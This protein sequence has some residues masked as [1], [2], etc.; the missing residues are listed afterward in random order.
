MKNSFFLF[1]ALL[2]IVSSCRK[3]NDITTT[4][5]QNDLPTILVSGNLVGQI[6]DAD[7][8]VVPNAMV[9]VGEHTTHS[10]ELGL[11]RFNDIKMNSRGTYITAVQDGYFLGSDRI[12]PLNGSTNFSRIQLL[13][14]TL[15]GTVTNTDGGT[16]DVS[17]A[18]V[19]FEPNSIVDEQGNI[20]DGDVQ[21]FA[22]WLNPAAENLGDFMPGG[23]VGINTEREEVTM[24]SM[25]MLVV[26]LLDAAGNELNLADDKEAV[27][28][29]PIPTS[30]RNIAPSTIPL[31]HFDEEA[32]LW[33]EEGSAILE[34]DAYIGSVKHFTFWN[35]DFPYGT[36]TVDIQGCLKYEDGT[37]VPLYTFTVSIEGFGTIIWGQTD[38]QGQFHGPV[39]INE[40]LV[41]EFYDGCGNLQEYSVGPLT[42]DTVLDGCF[43]LETPDQL[44]FT[45]Q[46]VDCEG[47]GVN[48][49]VV[50]LK[51]FWPWDII[52]TDA[53]GNFSYSFNETCFDQNFNITAYD[54]ANNLATETISY[55]ITEDTNVG[56]ISVC[57][58]ELDE[59]LS[60]NADG[61]ELDFYDLHLGI[62]TLYY[63][64]DS[65]EFSYYSIINGWGF[66]LEGNQ[67]N[68]SLT[69]SSIEVGTYTGGEVA[70]SYYFNSAQQG[71]PSFGL[72]CWIP[73]NTVTINITSN[74]GPGGFLEGDYI[75]TSDGYD[76]MQLPTFDKPVSGTFRVRIPN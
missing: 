26:E 4:D 15:A 30:L 55:T 56:E 57:D 33:I 13:T 53:D 39:P 11:F 48:E 6:I 46:L 62:D 51:G 73:C 65:I 1:L 16:I 43:I 21:V 7:G 2:L 29:F 68:I 76:S 25:G 67:S 34:K 8:A 47:E 14:K 52:I 59:I 36:E 49:G 74:G 45:G 20:V 60:S 40:V 75:G 22:Q 70:Y 23:L 28:Q 5:T 54:F 50:Y 31:W 42:E 24:T 27:L 37:P 63:S 3:D 64:T 41:F 72:N 18:K 12:Y 69:V 19:I 9:Q 44:T 17:G 38:N 35:V 66:D 61:Y 71:G 58:V 10:N 32:G